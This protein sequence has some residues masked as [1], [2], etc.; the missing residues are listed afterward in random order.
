M[1]RS[2]PPPQAAGDALAL[3]V[4]EGRKTPMILEGRVTVVG[5]ADSEHQARM[6]ASHCF[7][8]DNSP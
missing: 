7:P 1:I 4:Q 3:A 6:I 8:V 5:F 2:H